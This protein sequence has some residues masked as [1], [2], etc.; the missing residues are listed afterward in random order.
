MKMVIVLV[1][2]ALSLEQCMPMEHYSMMQQHPAYCHKDLDGTL[3]NCKPGDVPVDM[4]T[5]MNM[6][7]KPAICSTPVGATRSE[8]Q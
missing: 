6:K 4:S 7:P 5:M 8:C 3:M 1:G 2:L